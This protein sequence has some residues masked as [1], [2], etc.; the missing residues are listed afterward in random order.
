MSEFYES[1]KRKK[2]G[3]TRMP[4]QKKR[5]GCLGAIV[6]FFL[7]LAGL[8]L[9]LTLL[10][11][12]ALWALPVS[13]FA[14][15]P[16]NMELSLTDGLPSSRQNVLLLGIDAEN[17]NHQRSDTMIIASVGYDGLRLASLMRD[18]LAEI[19]G[20]GV[21]KLNAAYAHGG[22]ELTMRVV[23]EQLH[24]N[25]MK[26]VVVDFLNLAQ[27]VDALGGVRLDVTQQ[28]MEQ[29][30]AN[31]LLSAKLFREAG[32]EYTPLEKYGE[33]THLNGLQALGYAR[34][35]K[36]DSDYQRT[37][38]QRKLLAA[39][40]QQ[41]KQNPVGALRAVWT[42]VNIVESNMS[43]VE[44]VSLGLKVLTGG[45]IAQMRL[46]VDGTFEDNGS[47]LAVQDMEGN[48]RALYDFLYGA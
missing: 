45:N 35:R 20:Y 39:M 38:R 15:E 34:I 28:E 29:V 22:A 30:N 44:L 24:M 46:P 9:V 32:Y 27:I 42:A 13:L 12:L 10:A 41:A 8:C 4:V 48:R 7:K 18:M 37:S 23:N 11:G 43:P 16:E 1:Y 14:V 25:I 3:K 31:I 26:Y 21:E 2:R 5:R 33:G 36:I 40:V 6:C 19:P 47:S 17:Y